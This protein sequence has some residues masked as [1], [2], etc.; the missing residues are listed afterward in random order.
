[1]SRYNLALLLG[2][3]VA[4]WSERDTRAQ[5]AADAL[6]PDLIREAVRLGSDE[7]ASSQFLQ[8]YTSRLAQG[9]ALGP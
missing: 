4:V 8:S 3:L 7:K 6:T 5:G 1:M 9:W 2:L